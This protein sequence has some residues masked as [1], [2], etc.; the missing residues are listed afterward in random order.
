L[1]TAAWKRLN[2]LFEKRK[3]FVKVKQLFKSRGGDL[4]LEDENTPGRL[5]INTCGKTF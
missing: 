3:F 4:T 5:L 2:S 1:K